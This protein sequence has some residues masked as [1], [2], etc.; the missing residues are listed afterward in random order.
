M[1]NEMTFTTGKTFFMRSICDYEC[2]WF[3]TVV[4]RTAKTV[5]IQEI[6]E[7]GEKRGEEI[8]CRITVR[9]GVEEVSPKGKY[10]MSPVL[11]ADRVA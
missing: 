3:Y 7:N 1:S 9:D 4:K 2:K 11:K 5:T 8:R 6:D 10:S